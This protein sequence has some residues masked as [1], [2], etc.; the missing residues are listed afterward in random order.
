MVSLVKAR[1]IFFFFCLLYLL[2]HSRIS[3]KQIQADQMQKVQIVRV[4]HL[5]RS[6]LSLIISSLAI[7]LYISYYLRNS[8]IASFSLAFWGNL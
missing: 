4:V 2:L 6:I 7:Y 8:L 5:A 3:Q 1:C